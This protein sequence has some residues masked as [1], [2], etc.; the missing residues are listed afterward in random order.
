M[1]WELEWHLNLWHENDNSILWCGCEMYANSQ[2]NYKKTEVKYVKAQNTE[3]HSITQIILW[4]LL[5]NRFYTGN[6]YT[7]IQIHT[8]FMIFTQNEYISII[9]T[10]KPSN[11]LAAWNYDSPL[12]GAVC[13][14][15]IV[16]SM[17]TKGSIAC[18]LFYYF[19]KNIFYFWTII[20]ALLVFL[21]TLLVTT[22]TT[23]YDLTIKYN[24]C[25]WGFILCVLFQTWI[26]Y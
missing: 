17:F 12:I 6:P 3:I 4:L 2:L 5:G 7:C 8:V 23:L 9:C 1:T 19:L 11:W 18:L 24:L 21:V 20:Y 15:S 22:I 25:K 16:N 14:F 10:V 13:A 26:K